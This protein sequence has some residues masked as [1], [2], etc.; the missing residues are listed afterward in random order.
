[1][2]LNINIKVT[3]NQKN[4]VREINNHRERSVTGSPTQLYRPFR[5]L[6]REQIMS[7]ILSL[8]A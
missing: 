3:F 5:T 6:Q 4:K 2:K 1:M 7:Y 8:K